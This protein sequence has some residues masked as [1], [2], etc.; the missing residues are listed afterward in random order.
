MPLFSASDL[1]SVLLST[2]R[3]GA[4]ALVALTVG[5]GGGGGD[6]AAP[7]AT[8]LSPNPAVSAGGSATVTGFSPPSASPGAVVTVTGAGLATVKSASVG[9][10]PATFRIVSDTTVEVTVPN[11]A[12]TGRIELGVDGAVLLSASDLTVVA[13]P[14]ITSVTPTTVIPPAAITIAG[15]ALDGVREVRLGARTLEISSRTPTRLVVEVPTSATSGTLALIDNAGVSRPYAQ[16]I[17]VTGPLAISS[18]SPASI[19]A[20][21][22]L[23]V[24]GSNLDRVTALVFANGVT[25]SIASRTGTTRVFVVVPDSAGSGVFRLLG[26]LDDEVLSA[27]PLQVIPAIRVNAN[28]VY[29]VNAVATR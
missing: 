17:T 16:R 11:G 4:C 1:R 22:S 12:S 21:Q 7:T 14:T 18:F 26:N 3:L 25:A 6:S 2:G 10:V 24:N 29:R 19:V 27:T 15:T 20:G 9:S 8:Q 5:C 28:T 13:V 23:A